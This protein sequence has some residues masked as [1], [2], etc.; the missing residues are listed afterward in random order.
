[1]SKTSAATSTGAASWNIRQYASIIATPGSC[2]DCCWVNCCWLVDAVQKLCKVTNGSTSDRPIRVPERRQQHQHQ[3]LNNSHNST[4]STTTNTVVVC[5]CLLVC[6]TSS[7]SAASAFCAEESGLL[8]IYAQL[9][10]QPGHPGGWKLLLTRLLWNYSKPAFFA[11]SLSNG[12]SA[13]VSCMREDCW[14]CPFTD[15]K[16]LFAVRFLHTDTHN[17]NVCKVSFSNSLQQYP[18]YRYCAQFTSLRTTATA[19]RAIAYRGH[20]AATTEHARKHTRSDAAR[21]HPIQR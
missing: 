1:M 3:L 14:R 16:A 10:S 11:P 13:I 19:N 12:I 4:T 8:S 6:R 21:K 17:H 15:W 5:C 7:L 9:A 2:S 18:G 20:V